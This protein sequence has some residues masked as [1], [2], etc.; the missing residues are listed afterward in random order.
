[1]AEFKPAEQDWHVICKE[2]LTANIRN[3]WLC[4]IE[5]SGV[6]GCDH[7]LST[8]KQTDWSMIEEQK[9]VSSKTQRPVPCC[10]QSWMLT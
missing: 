1:M 5:R 10:A 8:P 9:A 6:F 2:N 7:E 4:D 3:G